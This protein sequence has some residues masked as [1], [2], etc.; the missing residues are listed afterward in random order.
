MST[1]SLIVAAFSM[2]IL[3]SF[4]CIGMC[5]PIALSI[6]CA[7][8][9]GQT[10]LK[11][12][13]LYNFG[14]SVS[15][16]LMG[17]ILGLIGNRFALAG[18][19]QILSIVAGS[20]IIILFLIHRYA[21]KE[22]RF[23]KIWFLKIQMSL[24]TRLNRPLKNI[25]HFEFGLINA[26]LPCGLVY[27]ALASSIATTHALQG[28]LFMFSFGMGTSPLMLLL[29]TTG[30]RIGIN[31]RNKMIKAIPVFI[32]VSSSFLILRGMNLGIPYLSPMIDVEN[33]CVHHCCHR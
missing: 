29:M 33:K 7:R 15:Y 10:G 13:F 20:V 31:F 14:R 1:A 12:H 32:L 22:I 23:L 8:T 17:G 30:R 5:G 11:Q 6:S 4:H 19:Q 24:V 3:G 21:N 28:A 18:Y 9:D 27:L 26:W 2:G 25:N 16:A